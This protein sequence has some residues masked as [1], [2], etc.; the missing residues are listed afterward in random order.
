MF[1]LIIMFMTYVTKELATYFQVCRP[2][3]SDITVF[4]EEPVNLK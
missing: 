1:V 3:E 2:L 4:R